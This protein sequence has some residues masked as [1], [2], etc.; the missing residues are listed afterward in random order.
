M[1]LNRKFFQTEGSKGG[2]KA[3]SNMTEQARKDRALKAVNARIARAK[4]VVTE[5]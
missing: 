3:A 1:K 2:L 4:K 5:K